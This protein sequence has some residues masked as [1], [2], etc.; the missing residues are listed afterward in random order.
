MRKMVIVE[1]FHH[2][3]ACNTSDVNALLHPHKHPVDIP[4]VM[5]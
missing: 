1:L 2:P 4:N 5:V 3:T